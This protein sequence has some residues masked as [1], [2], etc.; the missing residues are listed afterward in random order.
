[1]NERTPL[2]EAAAAQGAVFVEEAGW[3]MPAHYGD[4]AGEYRHT[5]EEAG[6]FDLS[7]RGK[8]ELTGSDAAAFLQNLATNDVAGLSYST[9]CETFFCTVQA[10]VIARA[11]IYHLKIFEDHL[12]LGSHDAYWLDLDPGLAEKVVQHLDHHL[13]SEQVEIGNRTRTFALL[14]LAGPRAQTLMEDANIKGLQN[15]ELMQM[16]WG[17]GTIQFRRHD[18]LGLPGYDILYPTDSVLEKWNSWL[19]AGARPAGLQTYEILRVEAGVPVQGRD[20]DESRLAPEV[21]RPQAISS[22]K[23]CYLGQEPIVRIR[24]RG[25]VNRL[26]TGLILASPEPAPPGS[27]LWHGGAGGGTRDVLRVVAAL[28]HGS[29]PGLCSPWTSRTGN[30]T[31]SGNRWGAKAGVGRLS[32]FFQAGEGLRVQK[33]ENDHDA[34]VQSMSHRGR[35]YALRPVGQETISQTQQE[36]GNGSRPNS[37]MSSSEKQSGGVNCCNGLGARP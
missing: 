8:L 20:I 17:D 3:Q 9:G 10:R 6:L 7:H 1:M 13:V 33:Q 18:L 34:V 26:L 35:N 23:G 25:H 21:G 14:H 29:R 27:K 12:F 11:L 28:G 15:L 16:G 4:P 19:K 5:V 30:R 31:G 32:S 37:P 24:D 22:T 2:Y 36:Q